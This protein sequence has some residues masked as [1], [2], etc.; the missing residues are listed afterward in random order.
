MKEL[1]VS[2]GLKMTKFLGSS[3][4]VC[5]PSGARQS[6]YLV[7]LLDVTMLTGMYYVRAGRGPMIT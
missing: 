5:I 7:A 3:A 1:A 6:Q 4:P 2:T